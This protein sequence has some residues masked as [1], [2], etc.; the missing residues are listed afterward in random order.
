L[1]KHP[2]K[3]YLKSPAWVLVALLLIGV[4]FARLPFLL[5]GVLGGDAAY[6]ARAAVTVLNGGLLYRDVPYTYPPLYAYTEALAIAALGTQ[7][8]AL[9]RLPNS[10]T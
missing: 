4:M 1:R 3:K 6:H 5:G 8:W 9:R 7:I 10:T 2:T